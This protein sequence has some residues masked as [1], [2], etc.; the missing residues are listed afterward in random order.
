MQRIEFLE[1]ARLL[2]HSRTAFIDLSPIKIKEGR[3]AL[4]R[5]S[6]QIHTS[7]YPFKVIYYYAA[8]TQEDLKITARD[9]VDENTHVVFFPSLEKQIRKN[10][11]ISSYFNKAKGVWTPKEYLISFIK[12]EVQSYLSKL[13]DQAP[14]YYV[15]PQVQTPSGFPIKTPNPLLSFLTDPVAEQSTGSLGVMLAEPGQGKT[16]MSRYLVSE[17]SKGSKGLVPLMVDSSQWHS[18]TIEDQRSLAKTIAHSFRHY[19]AT[20][21]WLEGHEEEFLEATL[22]ADIF[23]IVFDGFDE[24]ILRNKGSVQAL[25]TLEALADLASTTG[26]RIIITSRTSFWNTN[27]SEDELDDFINTSKS[28]IFK[29]SPF[30]LEQAKN[31][32]ANRLKTQKKVEY[33]TQVYK[34]VKERNQ[35]FAGRGFVLSLIA[36]LAEQE[37][38]NYRVQIEGS[39]AL[40]WLIESLCEREKLRQQLPFTSQEQ[41]EILR[42]F[43][44]EV[45]MGEAPNTELL[46]LAMEIT[47][48]SL[49]IGSLRATVEKFKSHPLL[50]K[51]IGQDKWYFKQEQIRML[52]LAH[53]IV[54]WESYE[55]KRFLI[56]A[57]LAPESWQDLGAMIVDIIRRETDSEAAIIQIRRI[58]QSMPPLQNQNLE[59]PT[60]PNDGCRLAA[61][62]AVTTV[63]RFFPKGSSH[64]ERSDLML[65]LYGGDKILN[66]NFTGTIGRYD[67]AGIT[68]QN[69]KF[70]RV[71]W[72]NCKF[73]DTTNFIQ[74]QFIGGIPPL[75]CTGFGSA[76]LVDCR[77]DAEA[78]AI[79]NSI[80]V[81]E[82]KKKYSA[83]D[84]RADIQCVINKF[85]IKGG[86]GLRSVELHNLT[87]GTISTSRYRDEIIEMLTS[88]VIEEHHISGKP[89]GYNVREEAIEAVKFYAGNNVL[90]GLLRDCFEKLQKKLSVS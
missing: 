33:A 60:R 75:Q 22:K 40:F 58:I 38:N 73:D 83:E 50:E 37:E 26:T 7:S 61:I 67:F 2:N 16:Y 19:G 28:Y 52:L 59:L 86:I 64:K 85:V 55:I 25:E 42:T 8:A 39:K 62:I 6:F 82:G 63:E 70:D 41:V 88:M 53:Q 79:F 71:T 18:M 20:I 12:D 9:I 80:R 43:A 21:G 34:A 68:F 44:I 23:R 66:V 4:Y 32:F 36:D 31:Y 72:A 5:G 13:S 69:C 56:K 14:S 87:R 57:R 49:D 17:I 29:I 65:R 84:L 45:A 47:N 3:W 24:Y 30:D 77:L 15:H 1:I 10:S 11:D 27:I 76:Q 51:D 89:G 74:C 90:T 48:P 78:N 54:K 46:S 35:D 81:K